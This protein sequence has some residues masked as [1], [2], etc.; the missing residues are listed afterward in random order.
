MADSAALYLRSQ[1]SEIEHK[2]KE[3]QK[4][5]ED[6]GLADLAKEEISSLELQ[7]ASLEASIASIEYQGNDADTTEAGINPNQ[8]TLELR[9]G[10]G[11]DEAK[12]WA[13]DLQR[14]YM[15]YLENHKIKVE[16][17]DAGY[18]KLSGKDIYNIFKFESGVH[19]VQRV[20]ETESQGRIH[21]ST[22]SVAVLP[23]VSKSSVE[24]RDEDLEWQFVRSGGAGGQNVNKVNTAVRLTHK[25]TGIMIACS[26]ERTQIR[27]RD[28][29]LELLRSRLWEIEEEKRLGTIDAQRKAAVGKATRAE[30]IRTF[31]FPQNRVTDHRINESW[32]NLESMLEGNIEEMLE[33]VARKMSDPT[34]DNEDVQ[35]EN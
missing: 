16:A 2:I 25:P 33:T 22:A 15:R 17:L 18:F 12:I 23:V 31:N 6:P 14:M 11:G 32:Y 4:L 30:K 13:D 5:L 9:A 19:R 1:I 24:I 20:P 29:A 28:L 7:K 35:T 10:T 27:N 8:A 3:A 34:G 21:T 26:Q